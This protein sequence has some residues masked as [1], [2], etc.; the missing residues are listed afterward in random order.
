MT[1]FIIKLFSFLIIT[2][3][4]LLQLFCGCMKIYTRSFVKCCSCVSLCFVVFY[5]FIAALVIIIVIVIMNTNL[6]CITCVYCLKSYISKRMIPVSTMVN[7]WQEI[8]VCIVV[9]HFCEL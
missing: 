8:K 1:D 6:S 3:F 2:V 5:G 9:C 4:E 7:V